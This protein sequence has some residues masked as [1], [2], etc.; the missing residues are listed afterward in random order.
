[1]SA[2]FWLKWFSLSSLSAPQ[3]SLYNRVPREIALRK[4]RENV[5]GDGSSTFSLYE[6]SHNTLQQSLDTL[7][8]EMSKNQEKTKLC[9]SFVYEERREIKKRATHTHTINFSNN[10][11]NLN[12]NQLLCKTK[13]KV[14]GNTWKKHFETKTMTEI[15]CRQNPESGSQS[16]CTNTHSAQNASHRPNT[17][18]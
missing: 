7:E 8:A 13:K 1:M 9:I 17:L 16:I 4:K 2:R 6:P 15:T 18:F 10:K 12:G 14:E 3:R 11:I 5:R